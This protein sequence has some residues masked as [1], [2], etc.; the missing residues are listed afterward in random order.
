MPAHAKAL[1]C[2]L[3]GVLDNLSLFLSVKTVPALQ[4]ALGLH[5]C[6]YFYAG[7]TLTSALVLYLTL[8]RTEG[9]SLEEIEDMF[10]PKHI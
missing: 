7:L 4:E 5:G 9:K 10:K 8:P 6:F 2:A 1:G 3:L